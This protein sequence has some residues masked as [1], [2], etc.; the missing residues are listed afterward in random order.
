MQPHDGCAGG[1]HPRR[2]HLNGC[3]RSGRRIGGHNIDGREATS[4][5]LHAQ[6]RAAAAAAGLPW[7]EV[8]ARERA[9]TR[10]EETR[11]PTPAFPPLT[12]G[13]RECVMREARSTSEVIPLF[14]CWLLR[15][16]SS[17]P[18]PPSAPLP[19]PQRGREAYYK[20]ITTNSAESVPRLMM[21]I[22]AGLAHRPG[23]AGGSDTA[24]LPPAPWGWSCPCGAGEAQA[25]RRSSECKTAS[26][27]VRA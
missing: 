13:R 12:P 7:Q 17:F 20:E 4:V 9:R 11:G 8:G 25:E 3:F 16:S 18:P 24:C 5:E 10:D 21:A 1:L 6:R 14:V 2:A 22:R 15:S 23:S 27:K 19:F 26:H